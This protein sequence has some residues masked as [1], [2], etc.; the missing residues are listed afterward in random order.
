MNLFFGYPRQFPWMD[1]GFYI[2]TTLI[3]SQIVFEEIVEIMNR[4]YYEWIMEK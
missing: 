4:R 1:K 2:I 3:F